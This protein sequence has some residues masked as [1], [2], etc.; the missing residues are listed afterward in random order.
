MPATLLYGQC[1]RHALSGVYFG[2]RIIYLLNSI[3]SLISS[4]PISIPWTLNGTVLLLEDHKTFF[5]PIFLDKLV[6]RLLFRACPLWGW[7]RRRT[8]HFTLD[9][10]LATSVLSHLS[11]ALYTPE[12]CLSFRT[13]LPLT[14]LRRGTF[15][16][17]HLLFLALHL[18]FASSY[19]LFPLI[20]F[21]SLRQTL[22]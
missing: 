6:S 19:F 5:Y 9:I 2:S 13:F 11:R 20:N 14:G 22:I 15:L 8:V 4:E 17:M 21:G 1:E 12:H 16:A 18:P 7:E 10:A 3:I